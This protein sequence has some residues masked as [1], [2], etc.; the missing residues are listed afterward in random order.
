KTESLVLLA[1]FCYRCYVCRLPF[2]TGGAAFFIRVRVRCQLRLSRPLGLSKS[3][4][5]PSGF[6]CFLSRGRGLYRFAAVPVN[7]CFVDFPAEPPFLP[8]FFF[9]GGA[10]S[11]SSPRF[12][13]T[14][15]VD[16]R[17]PFV[18]ATDSR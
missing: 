13:S 16:R 7:R 18:G 17:I 9:V 5:P 1:T 2:S 8:G 14:R 12:L 10:A 11:T 6:R 15:F 3:S 4:A